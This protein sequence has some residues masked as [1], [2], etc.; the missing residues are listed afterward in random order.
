VEGLTLKPREHQRRYA[1]FL[2]RLRQAR[3]DAGLRQEDVR[4]RI[5]EY[6]SYMS[7]VESGERRLDIIE[8]QELANIYKKPLDYFLI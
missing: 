5:G 4:E 7:K 1:A 3:M 2:K 8:L 6:Q